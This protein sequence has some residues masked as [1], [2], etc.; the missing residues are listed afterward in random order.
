MS[1]EWTPIRRRLAIGRT[2]HR[3]PWGGRKTG[4]RSIVPP[5]AATLA[6]TLAVRAGISLARAA[7][8]RRAAE[9]RE[10]DR[11]F[12]RQAGEPLARALQRMALGQLEIAI[13]QLAH[14]GESGSPEIA[15]HETRKALKRLRALLRLLEPRLGE[16]VFAREQATLRE[17]ASKLAGA[18]DGDVLLAT[19]DRLIERH[20]SKLEGRGG[21]LRLR[22]HLLS[23]RERARRATLDD[24]AIRAEVLAELEAC[25][26]RVSAW[27]LAEH[28][29]IELM[30]PGL[31]RLYRQGQARYRGVAHKRGNRTLAMHRWRKR[32]KDLRYVAQM[33]SLEEGEDRA[34]RPKRKRARRKWARARKDA[35]WLRRVER[36][37]DRLGELL[38]DEHDLAVLDAYVRAQGRGTGRTG[39]RIGSRSRKQLRKLIVKRRREL[40]VRALQEGE[41]LYRPRPQKFLSRVRNAQRLADE[42]VS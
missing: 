18:R 34:G 4:H 21:V 30:Q 26:V 27:R 38:G 42:G 33:L 40:R 28:G 3:P 20:P 2:A 39:V 12:A 16:E 13:E 37:A 5:L 24:P 29:D 9:Q 7:R 32:V 1:A 25:R 31:R 8:E 41:R 11:R 6:A 19:L 17:S 10:Q 23:E 15:I 35:A 36:R 22:A 14:G